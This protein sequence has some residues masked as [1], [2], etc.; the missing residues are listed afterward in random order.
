MSLSSRGVAT[1]ARQTTPP[2]AHELEL[3]GW[4]RIE[5]EIDQSSECPARLFTRLLPISTAAPA[6]A[7]ETI[8]SMADLLASE[9]V[10]DAQLLVSELVTHRV[11]LVREGT[12][13]LDVSI[14]GSGARVQVTGEGRGS[15]PPPVDS[16]EPALGW[17]LQIVA[18]IADRWGIRQNGS[19]TIWFELDH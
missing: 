14:T 12:L 6:M 4:P 11:R 15:A 10:R 18:E 17:E 19:T 8:A 13:R 16:D 9:L 3:P 5:T 7:R 1:V 2:A